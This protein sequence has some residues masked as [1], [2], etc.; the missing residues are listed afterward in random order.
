MFFG[1]QFLRLTHPEIVIKEIP[2]S[3]TLGTAGSISVL[4][5]T[6]DSD[7]RDEDMTRDTIPMPTFA[8]RQWT[9]SSLFLVDIQQN[10]MV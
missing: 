9:V 7:A 3:I 10:S 6:G 2:L 4:I 5:G 8:R 1:S